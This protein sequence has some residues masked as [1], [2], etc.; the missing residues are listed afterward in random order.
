VAPFPTVFTLRNARVHVYT[1]DDNYISSNIEL[2]IDDIL[3]CRT[4]LGIPNVDPNHCHI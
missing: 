1:M 4:A 2:A 3:C